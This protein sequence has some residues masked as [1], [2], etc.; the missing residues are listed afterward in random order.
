M[1]IVNST[2]THC[3]RCKRQCGKNRPDVRPVTDADVE[4]G[5][6]AR[7]ET[8]TSEKTKIDDY[9]TEL[10]DDWADRIRRSGEKCCTICKN[11][12][13]DNGECMGIK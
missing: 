8:I 13:H 5:N 4:A 6:V 2:D 7:Q 3:W 10:L 1:A 9:E 11:K 12:G